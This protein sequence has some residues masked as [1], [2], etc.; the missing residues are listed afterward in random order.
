MKSITW[1]AVNFKNTWPRWPRSANTLFLAAVDLAWNGC[2]ILVPRGRYSFGQH[3]ESGPLAAPN[4][5]SPR[6]TN[7]LSNLTNLI[8]WKL[9]KDFSAHA[10]KLGLARGFDSCCWPKGSWP[11]G[12]RMW[13]SH[14]NFAKMKAACI[15]W[16]KL[17]CRLI[18][19]LRDYIRTRDMVMWHWS[20]GFLFWQ[21]SIDMDIQCH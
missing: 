17:T 13:I 18:N 11:L 2:P 1:T 3:Q 10:Q 4:T 19:I 16:P 14:I 6:F 8:G 12:T 7:S 21:L 5:R 15:S 20:A 9:Y